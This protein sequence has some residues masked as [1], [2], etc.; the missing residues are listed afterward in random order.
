[1]WSLFLVKATNRYLS[2][3]LTPL[4]AKVDESQSDLRVL[5]SYLGVANS[6]LV[7]KVPCR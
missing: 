6:V 1:V 3:Y 7:Q 4:K 5:G 2:A